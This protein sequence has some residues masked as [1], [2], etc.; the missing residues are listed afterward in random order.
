M[1]N[2]LFSFLILILSCINVYGQ[3]TQFSPQNTGYN[4]DY[5]IGT[6]GAGTAYSTGQFGRASVI[7][8]QGNYILK[9]SQEN[10]NNQ[11]SYEHF[12]KND[13]AR[14]EN[15]FNKRQINGFYRSLEE[16]Q[17]EEKQRIKKNNGRL[18][19]EDIRYLY[20]R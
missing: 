9:Q 20:G 7:D 12:L 13:S 18:T 17:R 19:R 3:V 1:Y 15:I 6:Y 16:W 10:I 8:S 11:I 2:I 5:L 14:V 4:L